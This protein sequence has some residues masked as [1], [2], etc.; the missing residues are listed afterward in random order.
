[1]THGFHPEAAQEF[2]EQVR[3]YQGRGRLLGERFAA[4]VCF[5]IRR[6]LETPERWRVIEDDVR[7]CR[8][9]VFPF[10]VLYTIES[11]FILIL[12]VMH[13]KRQP[14]YWKDR[15]GF[16]SDEAQRQTSMIG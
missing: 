13:D 7:R 12:A 11:D 3:Y 5:A 10:S 6:I 2:D 15:L 9:R 4:E 16:P 8:V 14:G 1:M